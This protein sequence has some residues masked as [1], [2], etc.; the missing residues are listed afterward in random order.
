ME[1]GNRHHLP[2]WSGHDALVTVLTRA[3]WGPRAEQRDAGVRTIVSLLDELR[4]L[5]DVAYSRW[6][7]TASYPDHALTGAPSVD[8]A[9]ERYHR[10]TDGSVIEEM[11]FLLSAT[12]GA[13]E[14]GALSLRCVFGSSTKNKVILGM[15]P[16]YE[17]DL[18]KAQ[19][20]LDLVVRLWHPD[21]ANVWDASGLERLRL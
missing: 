21:E 9:V 7:P 13:F 15:P 3:F 19:R 5:D 2:I 10:D 12:N 16:H 1:P 17:Q 4:L 6:F 20:V 14:V 18:A 11:G 8:A